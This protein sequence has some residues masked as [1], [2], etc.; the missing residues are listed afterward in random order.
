M[1]SVLKPDQI[2]SSLL[3]HVESTIFP[4]QYMALLTSYVPSRLFNLLRT[5]LRENVMME[6]R[7]WG[8]MVDLGKCEPWAAR[9][10]NL[11]I[12]FSLKKKNLLKLNTISNNFQ[13]SLNSSEHPEKLNSQ[14]LPAAHISYLTI[15][16]GLT[17]IT[18]I[19]DSNWCWILKDWLSASLP[20]EFIMINVQLE[21]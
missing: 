19:G 3:L 2:P 4:N 7:S 13:N 9:H 15:P 17:R 6:S 8:I 12:S 20:C 18:W 16:C 10:K 11:Q 21:I 14:S 5:M 1:G